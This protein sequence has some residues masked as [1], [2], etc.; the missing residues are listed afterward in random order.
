MI[1]YELSPEQKAT[2]EVMMANRKDGF[3]DLLGK[4]KTPAESIQAAAAAERRFEDEVK[5]I[6]DTE[7]VDAFKTLDVLERQ[8]KPWEVEV[9][10]VT[11]GRSLAWV[12]LPGEIFVELGQ[13]VKRESPFAVTMPVELANGAIGYIPSRRAYP[14]GAYEVISAR[15]AAGSGEMLVEAAGKMLR[16]SFGKK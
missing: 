8:G 2:L 4:G 1:M 14:Q 16:D 12:S 9:Q 13:M 6:L 15:C 3:R 11:L 10:T 5:K 7:Q